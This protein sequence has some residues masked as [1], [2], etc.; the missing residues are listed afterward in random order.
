MRISRLAT[1]IAV[2]ALGASSPGVA[3]KAQIVARARVDAGAEPWR[4][5]GKLQAV[6]GGLRE[7]CTAA[8]IDPRTIVTAAH[9]LFNVRSRR[10]FLPPS[11]HFLLGLDGSRFAMATIVDSFFIAPGYDPEAP[12][13]TRGNDWA[14]VT[15]AAPMPD[16][17]SLDLARA[18][19]APG[20][21]VMVGGYGQDN[22]N[23]LT[24][25]M[26]CRVTGLVRDRGGHA[27][28]THD[29]QAVRGVSGAPLLFR[30]GARWVIGGINV[31]RTRSGSRGFAVPVDAFPGSSAG[32]VAR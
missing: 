3:S 31:A 26:D 12:D 20:T 18:P 22:P 4:S 27:L 14:L 19:P 32:Q 17:P 7:T 9:C 30:A 6:A 29:C 2:A 8:L 5:L 16:P 23:V 10:Y 11:M 24:A 13:E 28:L 1:L 21:A 15:L 25:D